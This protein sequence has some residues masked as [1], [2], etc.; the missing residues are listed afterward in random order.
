[1]YGLIP[2][3]YVVQPVVERLRGLLNHLKVMKNRVPIR[4]KNSFGYMVL[5]NQI[6]LKLLEKI[7]APRQCEFVEGFPEDLTSRLE[8]TN[9]RGS[10]CIFDDVMNEVSSNAI[11]L[12]LFT[13]GRSH[14]GCS[15]VLLLQNIFPKGSQS[16]TI[17]INAQFQVLFRNPRDSLQISILARQLCPLNSKDFLKIYKRA[18]QRPCGHLFCFF[19]EILSR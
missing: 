10:L 8:K 1:M 7:W 19:Y 9:D 18:T 17:S 6:F 3:F 13:H 14:L 11:T 12:K 15:L 2:C 5:N 4:L 16:R